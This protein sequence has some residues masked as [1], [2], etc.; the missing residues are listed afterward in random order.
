LRPDL[1]RIFSSQAAPLNRLAGYCDLIHEQQKQQMQKFGR[2]CGC[3][4]ISLGSELSTQDEHIRKKSQQIMEWRCKYIAAAI[5]DAVREKLVPEQDCDV[6]ARELYAC[7]IG[8]LLQ[9]RIENSLESIRHLKSS[10]FRLI[11]VPEK[12]IATT[13]NFPG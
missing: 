11:G 3:P 6:K 4:F 5:R 7:V 10:I 2:V 13:V 1:D 12:L 9:A 8:G